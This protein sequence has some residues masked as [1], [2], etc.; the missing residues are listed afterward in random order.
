MDGGDKMSEIDNVVD[1]H[2]PRSLL[3][4]LSIV[5]V[6]D[7]LSVMRCQEDTFYRC[8]DYVSWT[9][10]CVTADDDGTPKNKQFIPVDEE[11]RMKMCEWCYQVVDYCKL[12]R[13]T[14]S[15][16]MSFL[17]RYASASRSVLMDR[18]KYQLA[19][20]TSLYVAIKIFE[21][22]LPIS[23]VSDLSRGVYSEDEISKMEIEL[24][25]TLNW[26]V[27]VPTILGFVY[28]MIAILP[29]GIIHDD[30]ISKLIDFS[31]FQAELA[32]GDYLFMT[33]RASSIGIA[34]IMNSMG[35][36]VGESFAISHRYQFLKSISIA[37]GVMPFTDEID[38]LRSNLRN[39][40]EKSSGHPLPQLFEMEWCDYAFYDS[41][42]M[43]ASDDLEGDP[44]Q[45]ERGWNNNFHLSSSIN[46]KVN[47]FTRC[48]LV[49]DCLSAFITQLNNIAYHN[50]FV[51]SNKTG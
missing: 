7:R 8:S 39:V 5:E 20:M 38:S 18:R 37:C 45:E 12:R 29:E 50:C 14:V 13:E 44:L 15:I 1:E 43:E 23:S 40:F 36:I 28:H 49:D 41:G 42:K 46:R 16:S 6:M 25:F 10:H 32:V 17:D 2:S 24:L 27:S 21:P 31:Q 9:K 47:P 48:L 3:P 26:R 35:V 11:C 33:Q 30:D 22:P 4:R 34:A 51:A 19:A